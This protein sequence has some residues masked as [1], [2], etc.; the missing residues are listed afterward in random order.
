VYIYR[1]AFD[2]AQRT[3]LQ[4]LRTLRSDLLD[5]LTSIALRELRRDRGAVHL[6]PRL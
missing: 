5:S 3:V 1:V 4:T 6:R 2:A